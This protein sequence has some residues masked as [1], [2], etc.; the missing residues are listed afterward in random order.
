RLYHHHH[1]HHIKIIVHCHDVVGAECRC[2]VEFLVENIS[3][4]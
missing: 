1:H 4:R 2:N 3:H